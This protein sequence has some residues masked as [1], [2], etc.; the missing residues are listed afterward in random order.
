MLY[1]SFFKFFKKLKSRIL[2]SPCKPDAIDIIIPHFV[3]DVEES[4]KLFIIV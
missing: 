1:L 2:V 3:A 4:S